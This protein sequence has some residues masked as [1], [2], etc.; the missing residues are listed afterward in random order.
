VNRWHFADLFETATFSD[1]D[2]SSFERSFAKPPA[3]LLLGQYSSVK[4]NLVNELLGTHLLPTS[5]FVAGLIN[6]DIRQNT[7]I[8]F[9][10]AF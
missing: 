2:E 5:G 6:K 7:L 1:D 3:I 8:Q 4:F 10:V 9:C